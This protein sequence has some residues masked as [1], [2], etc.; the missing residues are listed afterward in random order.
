MRTEPRSGWRSVR[1]APLYCP[2]NKEPRVLLV[3][4]TDVNVKPGWWRIPGGSIEENKTIYE[5]MNREFVEEVGVSI[6]YGVATFLSGDTLPLARRTRAL[7]VVGLYEMDEPRLPTHVTSEVRGS[8]FFRLSELPH[9]SSHPRGHG[10][11]MDPFNLRMLIGILA[12]NKLSFEGKEYKDA[13]LDF[14][15]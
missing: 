5:A 11:I 3:L 13:M 9:L 1:Y 7:C 12:M 10:C 15:A 14:I 4:D 8:G 2:K 6:P